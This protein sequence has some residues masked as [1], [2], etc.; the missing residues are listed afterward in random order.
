M[1]ERKRLR[2]AWAGPRLYL[3]WTA[4]PYLIQFTAILLLG[5]LV[6]CAIT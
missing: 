4:M 3:C 2:F 5:L 6:A 1:P